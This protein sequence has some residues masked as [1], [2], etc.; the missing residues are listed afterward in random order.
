MT[1]KRKISEK[2]GTFNGKVYKLIIRLVISNTLP[3][4]HLHIH[5]KRKN[6]K[7]QHLQH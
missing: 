2:K 1:V 4:G 7:Y 3:L 6:N 5:T